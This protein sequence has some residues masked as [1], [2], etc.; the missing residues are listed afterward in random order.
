[1]REVDFLTISQA[2]EEIKLPDCQLVVGIAKGGVVPA[3]L[4]AYKMGCDLKIVHFNYRNEEN[5][6][7]HSAPLLV[8][9]ITLPENISSILLVDDVAISGKTLASAK[10]LFKNYKVTTMVLRGKADYVLF[11][12]LTTCVQ[13][14]WKP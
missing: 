6:P 2:L 3:S 1:M 7:Q 9:K 12:E 4:V 13:W 5:I 14:P 10:E 8:N 11:P